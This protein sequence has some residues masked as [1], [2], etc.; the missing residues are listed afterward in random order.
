M[1]ELLVSHMI[2]INRDPP[3]RSLNSNE[4]KATFRFKGQRNQSNTI[5]DPTFY[6]K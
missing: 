5:G 2:Y 4:I 3:D 1:S 6:M